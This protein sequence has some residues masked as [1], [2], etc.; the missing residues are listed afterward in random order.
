[1]ARPHRR[2]PLVVAGAAVFV[3]LAVWVLAFSP[4]LGVRTVTVTGTQSLTAGQVRTAAAIRPGSPLIR[5]D[6]AAIRERVEAL[7]EVASATV[8][9]TYPSTVR[10]RVLERVPVGYLANVGA[11]GSSFVLVDGSGAQYTEVPAA[12]A[13][14]PRFTLPAGS[15]AQATGHAVALVAAA[16][17]K[18]DLAALAQISAD[19]PQSISLILR[20][21]R[22][23]SWGSA[24]RSQ[25]KAALL[26][27]LLTQAGSHFDVSN[28]GLVVVR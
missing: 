23:V 20:D 10:I 12:P 19:T 28:P 14:L 1:L 9:V 15:G 22:T 24:D 21:G 25:Q 26:P 2:L 7:P 3:L 11:G 17:S 4:V 8:A 16:L 27:A 18:P 5:L 6:T 13:G